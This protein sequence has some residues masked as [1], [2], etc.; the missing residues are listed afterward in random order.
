MLSSGYELPEIS[1]GVILEVTSIET[2]VGHVWVYPSRFTTYLV[3]FMIGQL[4]HCLLCSRQMCMT[5]YSTM[6][7]LIGVVCRQTFHSLAQLHCRHTSSS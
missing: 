5:M 7:Q 3:F 4:F 2:W 1:H 6:F